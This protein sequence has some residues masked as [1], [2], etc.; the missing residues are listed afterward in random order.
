MQFIA[1]I[2]IYKVIVEVEFNTPV[3]VTVDKGVEKKIDMNIYYH[4]QIW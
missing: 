1:C 4:Q 2:S 3:E